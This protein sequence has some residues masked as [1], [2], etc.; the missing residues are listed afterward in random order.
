MELQLKIFSNVKSYFHFLGTAHLIIEF[1][2]LLTILFYAIYYYVNELCSRVLFMEMEDN[3]LIWFL[4]KNQIGENELH[5]FPSPFLWVCLRKVCFLSF[6][7][8]LSRL[9]YTSIR[10]CIMPGLSLW[11]CQQSMIITS[12]NPLGVTECLFSHSFLLY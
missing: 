1:T 10:R 12:I 6:R 9:C 5:N 8:P 4:K 2:T 7:R 11:R 3:V